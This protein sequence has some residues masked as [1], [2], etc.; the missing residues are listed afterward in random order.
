MDLYGSNFTE[1]DL[2]DHYFQFYLSQDDYLPVYI[3]ILR[4]LSQMNHFSRKDAIIF[5]WVK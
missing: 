2:A 5:H 4:S 3:F 1:K